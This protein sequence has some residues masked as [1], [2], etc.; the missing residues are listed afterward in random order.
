MMQSNETLLPDFTARN[1]GTFVSFYI[2]HFYL[3]HWVNTSYLRRAG[4]SWLEQKCEIEEHQAYKISKLLAQKT[5]FSHAFSR[6]STRAVSRV[7]SQSWDRI[8][9]R[10]KRFR[11]RP[12]SIVGIFILY[13]T[14]QS[15]L[16]HGQEV[17]RV[18][19]T[20]FTTEKFTFKTTKWFLLSFGKHSWRLFLFFSLTFRWCSLQW[21]VGKSGKGMDW[22]FQEAFFLT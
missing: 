19:S 22:W 11:I 5:F 10:F 8:S 21:I 17:K 20:K 18:A 9:V 7:D 1:K 12:S 3:S 13:Q 14:C 4:T 6:V 16:D 15:C 2:D